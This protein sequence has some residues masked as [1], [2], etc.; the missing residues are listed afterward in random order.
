M[1]KALEKRK[2]P[3][4]LMMFADEGHGTAKRSNTV[5]EMGHTIR[6]FQQHLTA[7]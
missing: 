1:Y 7:R 5:L 4:E 3:G 2:I 6:F